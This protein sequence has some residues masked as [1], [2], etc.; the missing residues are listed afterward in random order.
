MMGIVWSGKVGGEVVSVR[1]ASCDEERNRN[2]IDIHHPVEALLH[3]DGVGIAL[4]QDFK[5]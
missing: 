1:A 3:L 5:Q 4:L 2:S